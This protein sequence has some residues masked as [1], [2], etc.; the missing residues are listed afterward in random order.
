M[1]TKVRKRK[2]TII[3]SGR[4]GSAEIAGLDNAGVDKYVIVHSCN[5][6]SC[7]FLRHC[8]LLQCPSQFFS[9]SVNVHSCNISQSVA[10]LAWIVERNETPNGEWQK[11]SERVLATKLGN[12]NKTLTSGN[13]FMK[14]V[15]CVKWQVWK[16]RAKYFTSVWRGENEFLRWLELPEGP[17]AKPQH[18]SID[19]QKCLYRVYLPPCGLQCRLL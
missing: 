9:C 11:A 12:D 2:L 16:W 18:Q 6:H 19:T 15:H 13:C 17:V 3:D 8:P 7:N 4:D 10:M 14:H 5:V 1:E